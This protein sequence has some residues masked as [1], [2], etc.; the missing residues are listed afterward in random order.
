MERAR[1]MIRHAFDQGIVSF[2]LANNYGRPPGSAEEVFGQV[3]KTD[4]ARHRHEVVVTTKAGFDMWPGPYGVGSSRK[5][6]FESLDASL[7]RLG[8]DHVDI[9]YSHRYD[10]TVP[11]EE[12]AE[13]LSDIVRTGRAHYVGICSYPPGAMAAILDLLA[14]RRTPCAAIQA[15]YS[16]V[17]RWAEPTLMVEAHRRRLHVM[18]FSALAQGMLSDG[19]RRND[20]N[21]SR[22]FASDSSID[23]RRYA[24]GFTEIRETLARLAE[25][26][27][28]TLAQMAISWAM[29]P[30]A[31]DSVVF[32]ARTISQI[33]ENISALACRDFLPEELTLIDRLPPNGY[34]DAWTPEEA[35]MTLCAS[36]DS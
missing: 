25:T 4:F 10:A 32:G 5:Y 11:I 28:Q 2:D 6:L 33:D 21:G 17:S 26:R 31:A 3:M 15:S 13:A 30:G 24:P 27:R 12:T 35:T 16:L 23:P 14:E 29:R 9:F 34:N 1:G 20:G 8:M 7:K 36:Q 19:Y 18:A 22:L